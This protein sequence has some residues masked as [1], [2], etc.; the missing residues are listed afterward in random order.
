MKK[1][2]FKGKKLNKKVI[3]ALVTSV[4]AVSAIGV[5]LGVGLSGSDDSKTQSQVTSNIND[6]KARLENLPTDSIV[7]N[8]FI[9]G[10]GDMWFS[11]TDDF[12]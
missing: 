3:I 2:I 1:D 8:G 9:E 4:V 6:L 11:V 5:G 7:V 10:T 12:F